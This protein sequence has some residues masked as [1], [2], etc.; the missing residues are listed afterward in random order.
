MPKK[1]RIIDLI[2]W[3]EVYFK[4][5]SFKYPRV[6]IEW[7]I[8]DVLNINRID[9]YLNFDRVLYQKELKLIK[10]FIKR[11]I[12]REPFQYITKSAEFYGIE[13]YVN[14]KVLI[15]R[16]E[17]EKLIDLAKVKLSH[18]NNPSILDI[19]T[20]SGC[21][22]ITIALEKSGC[23]VI[24]IDISRNALKIANKNKNKYN[25]KNV[26]FF[27]MDILTQIPQ[28]RFDLIIS[29]PPYVSK[30]EFPNLMK[31][32]RDYEPKIALTDFSDG[33]HFYRRYSKIAKDILKKDGKMI[34][35]VGI[36]SH[37]KKVKQI[38]KDQGYKN[39]RLFK[40]YNGD[41]RILLV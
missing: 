19:G 24:G 1:W 29:N 27:E 14:K 31:D 33:L 21:I 36:G 39:A 9:I 12:K 10:R 22:A 41:F 28:N 7:I 32:V 25:L 38:F 15:P 37:P 18:L 3:A 13:F 34:L 20:G 6:E 30:K 17:T 2:N 40:D 16:P 35:E 8:R 5:K 26:R 11:R 4:Q 23:E